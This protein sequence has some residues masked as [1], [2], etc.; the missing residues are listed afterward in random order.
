MKAEAASQIVED[1]VVVSTR[2]DQCR[3]MYGE[4][5]PPQEPPCETCWVDVMP[6][7]IDALRIFNMVQNQFIMA[8]GGPIAINQTAIHPLMELYGIKD[9]KRCFEKVLKLAEVRLEEV[10]KKDK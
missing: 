6:E 7:N 2:C 5:N 10:N 4:R 3:L 8:M 9:K 1:G